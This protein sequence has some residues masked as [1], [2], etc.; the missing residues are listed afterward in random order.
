MKTSD[1]SAQLEKILR[2]KAR[3][4]AKWA[5]VPALREHLSKD[6][7]NLLVPMQPAPE[8]PLSEDE[9]RAAYDRVLEG[10][11][12]PNP[13]TCGAATEAGPPCSRPTP[14]G[15]RCSEHAG[16]FAVGEVPAGP[17][18]YV[19]TGPP[20]EGPGLSA[21]GHPARFPVRG[22][23]ISGAVDRHQGV[24]RGRGRPTTIETGGAFGVGDEL[25]SDASGRGIRA[26]PG[27]IVVA[28]AL[29]A[30]NGPGQ[31]AWIELA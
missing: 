2:A 28:V 24:Q 30:S 3:V 15:G 7:D 25:A 21:N 6:R 23:R 19:L 4:L 1:G 13:G 27:N 8:P 9:I 31:I 22:G 29:E 16:Q 18:F 12:E 17:R 20:Q 5:A 14:D 11:R 10:I 26:E